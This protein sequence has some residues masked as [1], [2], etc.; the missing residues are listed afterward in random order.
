MPRR[1]RRNRGTPG[2]FGKGGGRPPYRGPYPSPTSSS[3]NPRRE[4]SPTPPPE[5]AKAASPPPPQQQ[6]IA[7]SAPPRPTSEAIGRAQ[8]HGQ[9]RPS[10][11]LAPPREE[12]SDLF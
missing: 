7:A 4:E 5:P 10:G 12:V 2:A 1:G 3:G 8:Q 9:A 6:R 11:A